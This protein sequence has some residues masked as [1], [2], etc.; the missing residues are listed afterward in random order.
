M[1][2]SDLITQQQALLNQ[3][4]QNYQ[5]W[6]WAVIAIQFGLM[7]I[8]ACV[9]Y[10]FY[11]RLRDI[12]QELMKLRIICEFANSPKSRATRPTTSGESMTGEK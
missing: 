10:L 7:L 12:A 4:M 8:A 9:I 11:A 6:F 2:P 1:N 3:A 5:S